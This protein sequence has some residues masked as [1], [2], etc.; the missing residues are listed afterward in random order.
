[1]PASKRSDSERRNSPVRKAIVIAAQ[2]PE[3]AEAD[4][5]RSLSELKQLLLG[6]DIAVVAEVVQKRS[7]RS[8]PTYLG[9]GK[10]RELAALTGG[11]GEV[12]RGPDARRADRA[13]PQRTEDL[14]V[15]A[16]D[17]LSPGQARNL[18]A[19]LGVDVL[20]RTAVILRVFESRARTREARLEIELARLEIELPRI[21]DDHA[22]GDR[23]GGG[24][25]A[26]RGHT[27]VEL[28][29]QRAR[30]RMAA[31]RREL[32][33]LKANAAQRRLARADSFRV[34]LV[35]YTN[36]GK[37]SIMRQLTGSE[38]LVE[39]KLF[40]TLGT[41]VRPLAPPATPAV[42]VADTVGFIHRLPHALVASFHATLSEAREAWLLL[43]VVDAADPAF[44]A[45]IRVTEQVLA[46][47]GAADT[48]A[49]LLLNKADRLG[50]EERDALAV[51]HPGALLMSA[52]DRRDGD[53]LRARIDAFFAQHLVERT[54]SIPYDRQGVLAELRD[55]LQVVREEYGDELSVTVRGTPEALG[56]LAA[57][58]SSG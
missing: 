9:E 50:R 5:H 47:I 46:D 10:L 2:L 32:E 54:V 38:V 3:A 17:E 44:R 49:L 19:A 42:L 28:A 4:V 58:L 24:G 30:D 12:P 25:R 16:D 23:E 14:V 41:T 43:H 27:N 45:Q 56:K 33:Q 26:S 20:D 36:A 21:R 11:T 6:L 37:S 29:K 55:R 48:P 35:G 40:A 39:D 22:L 7:V 13:A 1:M 15:V 51:E 57:R 8:S 34:A 53:A 31:A 18:Q 52:L